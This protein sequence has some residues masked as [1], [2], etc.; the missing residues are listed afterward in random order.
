MGRQGLG[1]NR[2]DPYRC[3]DAFPGLVGPFRAAGVGSG[4]FSIFPGCPIC[5]RI[6]FPIF[7]LLPGVGPAYLDIWTCL[8]G[9][10]DLY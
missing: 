1:S 2:V 8:T 3:Q 10:Q 6:I 4:P 9:A 5:F 7:L